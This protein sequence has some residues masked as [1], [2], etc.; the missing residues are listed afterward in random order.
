MSP[1]QNTA[2]TS[3]RRASS[4]NASSASEASQDGTGID[5]AVGDDPRV[6]AL[7]YAGIE[8]V[9]GLCR[10]ALVFCTPTS[11]SPEIENRHDLHSRAL[12]A[13]AG[14]KISKALVEAGGP[15]PIR[16]LGRGHDRQKPASVEPLDRLH[17]PGPGALTTHAVVRIGIHVVEA[18]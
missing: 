6:R 13:E 8:A 2:S 12:D 17:R 1:R 15:V 9:E 10:E 7:Q 14:Q 18:H 5:A 4:S 11:L 16:D 3:R